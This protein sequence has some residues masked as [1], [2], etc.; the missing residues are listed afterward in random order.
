MK[1]LAFLS[2]CSILIGPLAALASQSC[3]VSLAC[4]F[5]DLQSEVN[6]L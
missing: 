5:Y 1:R 4:T 2:L 6:V 3:N